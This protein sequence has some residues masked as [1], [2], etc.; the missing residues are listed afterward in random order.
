MNSFKYKSII[1]RSNCIIIRFS[2]VLEK[3]THLKYLFKGLFR[4]R[5]ILWGGG[6]F[7]FFGIPM[8]GPMKK[9][10]GG[11]VFL[12]FWYELAPGSYLG[13]PSVPYCSDKSRRTY[14]YSKETFC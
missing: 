5:G 6:P 4:N 8:G 3:S 12:F 9:E 13:V 10:R 1:F 11:G 7:L 2:E 14:K